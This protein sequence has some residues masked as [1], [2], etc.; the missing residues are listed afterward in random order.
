MAPCQ[1]CQMATTLNVK[2]ESGKLKSVVLGIA[3]DIEVPTL[4]STY[5]PTS[6]QHLLCGTYPTEEAMVKEMDC[7]RAVLEKHSVRV[8]RPS[9]IPKLNQIFARDVG[10]VID[11]CFIRSHMIAD[12]R[13]EIEGIQHLIAPT[14]KVLEPPQDALIEGGDVIVW[15]EYIF[16]GMY[17]GPDFK[18]MKCARTNTAG[19]DFIRQAF[20]HKKVYEFPLRKSN[21]VPHENALHLDCCFQPLGTAEQPLALMH[22]GGFADESVNFLIDL[23][24]EENILFLSK[25]DMRDM[26][27]NVFSISPTVVVS[28][29]SFVKVNEWLRSRGITVE[30][31]EYKEIGK[32]GGLMRC[33]TLPLERD[34]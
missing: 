21:T 2:S 30:D 11:N 33:S 4:E 7:F 14:N 28:E 23:I 20:P 18:D 31:I 24:G 25:E 9:N 16:I 26:M 29:S 32:Q 12:R 1:P 8:F 22:K 3:A 5:D 15:N 27:A 6:R 10:F 34:E 13:E 19:V 17:D